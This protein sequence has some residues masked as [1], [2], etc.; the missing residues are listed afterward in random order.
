MKIN[1]LVMDYLTGKPIG[2][3][4]SGRQS[5]TLI[6]H[7]RVLLAASTARRILPLSHEHFLLMAVERA[8]SL[9]FVFLALRK[10][11][12]RNAQTVFHHERPRNSRARK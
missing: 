11:L 2:R 9:D 1:V 8:Q 4:G 3:R 5:S 7:D 12:S 10:C 6:I